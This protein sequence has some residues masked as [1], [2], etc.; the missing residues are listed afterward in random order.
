VAIVIDDHLLLDLL[1]D[2]PD[3]WLR[4]EAEHAAT[5]TTAAWYYRLANA[6]HRGSGTGALSRKLAALPETFRSERIDNLT[7]RVGLVGPRLL[8]PVMA[9]LVT[10][11]RPNVLTAEALAVALITDGALV[12]STD[13]QLLR[14]GASDLGIEY[15]VLPS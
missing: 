4:A 15:R 12:V 1:A 7:D 5:Y 8:V 6:A 14:D 3:E 13:A 10:Q 2:D 11:R 9:A